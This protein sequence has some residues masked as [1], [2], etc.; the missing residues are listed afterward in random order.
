VAGRGRGGFEVD[1]AWQD[2]KLSSATIRSAPGRR[3]KARYGDKT[4]ELKLAPGQSRN[5]N[6]RLES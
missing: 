6:A 4:S 2:G 5:F 3:G 1:I